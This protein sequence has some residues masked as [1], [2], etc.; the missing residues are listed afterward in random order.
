MPSQGAF[1]FLLVW[2]CKNISGF[3][4]CLCGGTNGARKIRVSSKRTVNHHSHPIIIH[5]LIHLPSSPPHTYRNSK[6]HFFLRHI[7]GS[8]RRKGSKSHRHELERQQ[9]HASIIT[10]TYQYLS[11]SSQSSRTIYHGQY[12]SSIAS[13]LRTHTHTHTEDTR[14]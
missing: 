14:T 2:F 8:S 11:S 4:D 9:D 6:A 12:S 3:A 5:S 13:F 1:H 7:S 10:H